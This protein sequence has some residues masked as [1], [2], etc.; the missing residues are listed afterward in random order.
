MQCRIGKKF[1]EASDALIILQYN[2]ELIMIIEY[3]TQLY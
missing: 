2:T 3:A 1:F